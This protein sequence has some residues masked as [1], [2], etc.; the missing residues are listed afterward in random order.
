MSAPSQ[1][2]W[3]ST[4]ASPPG[5]FARWK[6]VVLHWFRLEEDHNYRKTPNR[7]KYI[8]EIRDVLG[9]NRDDLPDYSTIYK[10][11]ERLKIWVWQSLLGISA[12]QHPQSDHAALDSTF[13]KRRSASSYYRRRSRSNIQ[14]LKV[15]TLTDREPLPVLDVH[16]SARWKHDTKAGPQVVRRTRKTCY[17][18][19]P[20]KPST[21]GSRNTSSMHLASNHSSYSVGRGR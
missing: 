5:G 14:T 7:L 3:G 9:L 20:I 4:R 12:Q 13:F 18:S 21:T 11:F 2:A 16:I 10:S 17:L 1:T 6:H 8:A 15:T 19:P